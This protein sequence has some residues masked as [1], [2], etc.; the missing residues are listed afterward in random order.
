VVIAILPVVKRFLWHTC[1]Y[2]HLPQ[3]VKHKFPYFAL[4]IR[5]YQVWFLKKSADRPSPGSIN[6]LLLPF[7]KRRK[8][9]PKAESRVE[10]GRSTGVVSFHR[11][12]RAKVVRQPEVKAKWMGGRTTFH[13]A[14]RFCKGFEAVG[15]RW[16]VPFKKR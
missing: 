5:W 3:H 11:G 9:V 13:P 2:G 14:S 7:T 1:S 8:P 10:R 15:G 12:R 6:I 4:R 16:N